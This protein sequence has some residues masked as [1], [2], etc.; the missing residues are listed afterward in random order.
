[1]GGAQADQDFGATPNPGKPTGLV[2]TLDKLAETMAE[3]RA[4]MG[5]KQAARFLDMSEDE[6]R[7]I[8]PQLPRHPLPRRDGL[9]YGF[10]MRYRYYAPELTDWLLSRRG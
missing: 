8:A 7:R 1:V 2:A 5:A 3:Q 6:F 9:S 4:W 10:R